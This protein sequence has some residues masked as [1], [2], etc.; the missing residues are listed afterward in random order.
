MKFPLFSIELVSRCADNLS[1]L[2]IITKASP[3]PPLPLWYLNDK[4]KSFTPD[5]V[6]QFDYAN[7][8]NI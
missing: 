8:T 4:I 3:S 7:H 5:Y 6:R 1:C 2:A